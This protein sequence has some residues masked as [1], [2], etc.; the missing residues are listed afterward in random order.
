[1]PTLGRLVNRNQGTVVPDD[2][3]S[4]FE[5]R[6]ICNAL[7]RCDLWQLIGFRG[8]ALREEVSGRLC[9]RVANESSHSRRRSIRHESR[10]HVLFG[11]STSYLDCAL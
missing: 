8:D 6:G 3:W 7:F 4:T 11:L 1:M 2:F 9:G 10:C 5:S